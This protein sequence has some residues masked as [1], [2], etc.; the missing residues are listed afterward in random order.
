VVIRLP[1]LSIRRRG[2][3]AD[4]KSD[5]TLKCVLRQCKRKLLGATTTAARDDGAGAHM[6]RGRRVF[7]LQSQNRDPTVKQLLDGGKIF[8]AESDDTE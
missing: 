3:G 5:V 4:R 1:R 7:F 8:A 2:S 6:T